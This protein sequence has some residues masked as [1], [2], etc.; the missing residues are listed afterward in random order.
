MATS[1]TNMLFSFSLFLTLVTCNLSGALPQSSEQTSSGL[2]RSKNFN[3]QNSGENELNDLIESARL[4]KNSTILGSLLYEH[5]WNAKCIKKFAEEMARN[6]VP[7][8]NVF[9]I[10]QAYTNCIDDAD[11]SLLILASFIDHV[12]QQSVIDGNVNYVTYFLSI[13]ECEKLI[14]TEDVIKASKNLN[15]CENIYVRKTIEILLHNYLT[16]HLNIV[17]NFCLFLIP[18]PAN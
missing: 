12:L 17:L 5:D 1:S 2:K 7:P 9:A 18:A 6:S 11:L 13:P 15:F 8:Q 10:L 14:S 4:E 16:Q 3:I